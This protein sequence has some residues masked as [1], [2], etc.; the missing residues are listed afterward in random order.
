MCGVYVC[1]EGAILEIEAMLLTVD[2]PTRSNADKAPG[3]RYS[4]TDRTCSLPTPTIVTSREMQFV[5]VAVER[6]FAQAHNG[7][8][9]TII[10]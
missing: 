4:F 5:V 10:N 1:S 6:S 9:S 2:C 8:S 3:F 7:R